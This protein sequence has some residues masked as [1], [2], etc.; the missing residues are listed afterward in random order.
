MDDLLPLPVASP[1]SGAS[2]SGPSLSGMSMTSPPPSTSVSGF[3]PRVLKPAGWLDRRIR[4]PAGRRTVEQRG[5]SRGWEDI[6]IIYAILNISII[7]TYI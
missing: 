4:N 2:V 1:S 3:L 5:K 7:H 6:Y